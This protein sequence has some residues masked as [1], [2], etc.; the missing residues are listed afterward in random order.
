VRGK[1]EK[2]MP[3]GFNPDTDT[4]RPVPDPAALE[5]YT[6]PVILPTIIGLQGLTPTKI[7]EG[8]LIDEVDGGEVSQS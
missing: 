5:G 6:T 3:N 4:L 2:Q 1:E 8:A 7:G